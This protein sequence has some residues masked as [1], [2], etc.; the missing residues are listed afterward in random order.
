MTLEL[1]V[2][3]AELLSQTADLVT[4]LRERGVDEG[5]IR[6]MVVESAATFHGIEGV[7]A[8]ALLAA[9]D[10]VGTRH[11]LHQ[12]LVD[13]AAALVRQPSIIVRATLRS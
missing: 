2:W 8:D 12:R 5:A 7:D 13:R 3:P 9:A 1:E 4:R 10:P 11:L 6:L